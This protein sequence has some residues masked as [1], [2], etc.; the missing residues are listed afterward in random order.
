MRCIHINLVGFDNSYYTLFYY[1]YHY[2]YKVRIKQ[3]WGP[4][5]SSAA[6]AGF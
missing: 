2:Y 3:L 4:T 5:N 1:Y 6:A